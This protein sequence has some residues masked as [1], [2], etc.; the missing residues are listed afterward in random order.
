M[1]RAS[2]SRERAVGGLEFVCFPSQGMCERSKGAGCVIRL[3]NWG[4]P[5][6]AER[7]L[8]GGRGLNDCIKSSWVTAVRGR[9][10]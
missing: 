6:G 10:V 7:G 5:L 3:G 2:R 4:G 9:L 1:G 8:W